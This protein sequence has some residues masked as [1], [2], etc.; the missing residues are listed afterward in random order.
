M[1]PGSGGSHFVLVFLYIVQS[2]RGLVSRVLG[3]SLL[4]CRRWLLF[5]LFVSDLCGCLW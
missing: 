4:G 5:V 2:P 3:A 1:G